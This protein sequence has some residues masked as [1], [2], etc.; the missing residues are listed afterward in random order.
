MAEN[1]GNK[2]VNYTTERG[3]GSSQQKSVTKAQLIALI[4]RNFPDSPHATV[5][6]ITTTSYGDYDN[7]TIMQGI[8]LGKVLE[9]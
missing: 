1:K 4:D 5:A 8:T 2:G 3:I 7:P 9:D 6:V